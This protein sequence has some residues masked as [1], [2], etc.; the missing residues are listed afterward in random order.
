MKTTKEQKAMEE[1]I[2]FNFAL[3]HM[4]RSGEVVVGAD[5][6]YRLASV[7][8]PTFDEL[9]N[10]AQITVEEDEGEEDE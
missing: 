4:L 1:L 2:M 10:D 5:G 9:V 8:A 7:R 3:D 6:R